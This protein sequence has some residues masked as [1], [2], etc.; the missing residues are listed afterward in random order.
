MAQH[1]PIDSMN[2]D[3]FIEGKNIRISKLVVLIERYQNLSSDR[4]K[5]EK[6]YKMYQLPKEYLFDVDNKENYTAYGFMS[7]PCNPRY[8]HGG[9]CAIEIHYN[10]KGNI[11]KA[12]LVA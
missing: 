3:I 12:Y 2:D 5:F 1:I 11:H 9:K 7:E 6:K 4:D 10:N 8:V